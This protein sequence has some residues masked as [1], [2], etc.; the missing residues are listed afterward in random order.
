MAG[1]V[2]SA[3]SC[4]LCCVALYVVGLSSG[5]SF[6]S[7][8]TNLPSLTQTIPP[9]LSSYQR[10]ERRTRLLLFVRC[11]SVMCIRL[12]LRAASRDWIT[13]DVPVVFISV[14]PESDRAALCALSG[15]A[16]RNMIAMPAKVSRRLGIARVP[17]GVIVTG[18]G[19][20]LGSMEVSTPQQLGVLIE[21]VWDATIYNWWRSVE[22]GAT[23]T[24]ACSPA[25]DVRVSGSGVNPG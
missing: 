23:Y 2:L 14:G 25:N 17:L 15:M 6:H 1:V 21:R 3:I 13:P 8:N 5:E 7:A 11:T 22:T 24:E 16:A 4:G 18:K 20:V 9:A 19:K 12:C 10:A